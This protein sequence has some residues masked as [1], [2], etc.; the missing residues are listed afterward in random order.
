VVATVLVVFSVFCVLPMALV[1]MVSISDESAIVRNG[2]SLIPEKLSLESYRMAFLGDPLMLRS[3]GIS[4]FVTSFGTLLAVAITAMAA[5]PL[6]NKWFKHANA[7]ALFFFITMQ[8]IFSA[9]PQRD[10]QKWSEDIVAAA[11]G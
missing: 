10:S 5:Y 3:M 2:F 4:V 8:S 9:A 11:V 6:A 7:F 1:F